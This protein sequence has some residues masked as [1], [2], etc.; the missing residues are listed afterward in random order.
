[1]FNPKKELENCVFERIAEINASPVVFRWNK[2]NL[3]VV[4]NV[5]ILMEPTANESIGNW[6]A[7]P[8]APNAD[9]VKAGM[10]RHLNPPK[11]T[12]AGD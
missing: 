5:I 7:I 6:I 1:M 3:G 9:S 8:V 11:P 2:F 12:V 4:L 10:R